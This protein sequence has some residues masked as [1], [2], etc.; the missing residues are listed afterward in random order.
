ML[1]QLP[2]LHKLASLKHLKIM[3]CPN[4][5]KFPEEFGKLGGFLKLEVF[6]VMEVEKLEQLPVVEEGALPSLKT[7]AI[8]KCEELQR[9]PQSYWNLKSVEKI[10]VYGCSKVQLVMAEEEEENFIKTKTKVQTITLSTTET[11]ALEERYVNMCRGTAYY[12]YGEFWSAYCN[13]FLLLL[14]IVLT[15]RGVFF[16]PRGVLCSCSTSVYMKKKCSTVTLEMKELH[17]VVEEN[18]RFERKFLIPFCF[19]PIF[20]ELYTKADMLAYAAALVMAMMINAM[21]LR[22]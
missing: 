18:R 13:S 5:E 17:R 22:K 12:R 14:M 20:T 10:R 21:P 11:Q 9:L 7:L 1:K 8:M 16:T 4:I 3:K 6:S 2:A 15:P 19:T